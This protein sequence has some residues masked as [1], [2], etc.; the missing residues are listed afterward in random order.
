MIA[1]CDNQLQTS[2]AE[3]QETATTVKR[4][5][6]VARLQSPYQKLSSDNESNKV[7]QVSYSL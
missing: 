5:T 3:V 2:R 6:K 4:K 1:R 7:M